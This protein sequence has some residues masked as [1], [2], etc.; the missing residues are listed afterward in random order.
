MNSIKLSVTLLLAAAATTAVAEDYNLQRGDLQLRYSSDDNRLDLNYKGAALL[1]G[2]VAEADC[3]VAG[4]EQMTISAAGLR[5]QVSVVPV[6]DEFGSGE[7]MVAEYTSDGVVMTQTLSLYD[8]CPYLIARVSLRAAG[9]ADISSNRIVAFAVSSTSTPMGGTSNRILWVPYDN[10]GHGAYESFKIAAAKLTESV[11]HEVGCVYNTD[12]RFGIV[13]GAVDHDT[14]KNG[15]TIAGNYMAR[16]DRFEC[17]SGLSNYF[18]RDALPHGKVTGKTVSSARFMVGGFDDWREGM[19]AFGDANNAVAPRL[20]WPDGNPIGWS[21]YGSMQEKV[22]YDGV[23]EC[24]R[25]IRDNLYERGFHNANGQSVISLDA[26]GE[27]NIPVNRLVTLSRNVFG[28]GTSYTYGG[29][30]YDGTNM[31]LGLY[32]GP[33]CIWEWVMDSK[34]PGTGLNG[35]PDYYFRDM[36]LKVNGE[37]YKV[38]SNGAYASDP[39]HPAVAKI[40]A[41]MCKNYAD[42]GAKYAKVDFMNCGMVQ[43]DSYYLP[44]VTTAVQAY[45]YAMKMLRDEAAKYGMYVVMAMSPAFPYEYVH[46]RRTCC[47]RFSEI[48]ESEYVMNAT[49]YGFWMDRLYSVCDPDQL[50]MCRNDLNKR[51]TD[52]ENRVRATTGVVTGA[53]IWGDNFSDKVLNNDGTVRGF[54]EETRQRALAIMGN[55]EINAYVREHTGCFMPVECNGEYTSPNTSEGVFVKHADDA[56]YVAVFN[57]GTVLAKS[58]DLKFERLGIPV[59]E[60]YSI[61]ELWFGEDVAPN[62]DGSGFRYNVPAKDVRVYKLTSTS[63]LGE[64]RDEAAQAP[65]VTAWLGEGGVNVKANAALD[66]VWVYGIDGR[67]LGHGRGSE[68]DN[69]LSVGLQANPAMAIVRAVFHN[70]ETAVAK[71][72]R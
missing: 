65:R 21:S 35:E 15:V 41:T 71:V 69:E 34:V 55:E 43:G 1:N 27:D 47:D 42:R 20:E 32:G 52:G 67:L 37:Y 54:P 60:G 58:G 62:A 16:I 63:S 28:D 57:F 66:Q 49:S 70:G 30:K 39:T 7:A 53:F 61:R 72:I 5:P 50:V 40:I 59:T 6:S 68:A 12:S 51:E 17:L 14:W 45:N 56:T 29:Q 64:I 44:E 10:D 19:Y 31:V 3:S 2:I 38:P 4:G 23:V 24:A 9:D 13:A 18:T 8:G 46:G 22:N 26:C 48:G 33:F 11:S 25:F 36:A